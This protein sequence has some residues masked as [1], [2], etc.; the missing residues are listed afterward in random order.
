MEQRERGKCQICEW[1]T[2]HHREECPML[3]NDKAER[4]AALAAWQAGREAAETQA[5]PEAVKAQ[6][7]NQYFVKAYNV[8]APPPHPIHR[9]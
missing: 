1:P 3:L 2:E 5:P 7:D 6:M 9:M 4:T 8:F